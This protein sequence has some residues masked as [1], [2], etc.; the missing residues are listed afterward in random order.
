MLKGFRTAF[1]LLAASLAAISLS[2]PAMA[3]DSKGKTEAP[4]PAAKGKDAPAK[5]EAAKAAP[6]PAGQAMPDGPTLNILIR[7]TLLTI[8]DANLS[9]NYSVLYDLAAPGFQQKNDTKKLA[10]I[11]AGLRNSKIDF[12]PIV[13]FDPKLIRKPEFT[14]EGRIRLTGFVPTQPQQVNFDML[15]ENLDGRW[16]IDSVAVNTSP[17]KTAAAKPAAPAAQPPAAAAAGKK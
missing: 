2:A 11:F 12:A 9:G 10:E 4:K 16:R 3:Q 7:R 5:V 14:K 17:A 6:A 13:Y 1:A 8:N 15:F